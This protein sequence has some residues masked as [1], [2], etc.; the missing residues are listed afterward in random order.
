MATDVQRPPEQSLNSL[1]GGIVSDIQTLLKQ[2]LQLTR[3]EIQ[4]DLIK[5]RKAATMGAIGLTL[6]G[7]GVFVLSLALALLLYWVV[8]PANSDPARIPLWGCF[9]IVSLAFIVSGGIVSFFGMQKAEE[10]GPLLGRSTQALEEN[11]E[12]TTKPS[13]TNRS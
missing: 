12:W 13:T 3:K 4:S 7:M 5:A 6:A 1:V 8:S 9:G 10:I 11:L 2:Q